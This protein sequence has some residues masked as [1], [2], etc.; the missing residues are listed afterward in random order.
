MGQLRD[1]AGI[2]G[3]AVWAAVPPDR[4]VRANIPGV[5]GVRDERRPETAPNPHLAVPRVW[6]VAG[7]GY[8]RGGSRRHGRRAGGDSLWSA[9]KTGTRPGAA[10][11]NRNPPDLTP[12]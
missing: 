12:G 2:Q 11:G 1:H 9:G 7:P 5:F 3:P 8:Q 6:G 4:P 10:R